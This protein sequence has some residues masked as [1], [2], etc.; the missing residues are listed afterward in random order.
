MCSSDLLKTYPEFE[1]KISGEF[2]DPLANLLEAFSRFGPGEQAWYQIILIPTDQKDF[3]VRAEKLINKIKGMEEK[4]KKTVLDQVIELPIQAVSEVLSVAMGGSTGSGKPVEKKN[5]TPRMLTLSPG[6]RYILEAVERKQSKIG[7]DCK[8][9]FLYVAKKEVMNKEKAANPFIGAIKQTN[10]F[11]MQALKPEMKRVGN[12]GALWWF[13]SQ[14]NNLRKNKMILAYR[15][16]SS[17]SGLPAFHMDSEELATL[18]HFPILMQVKAPRLRRI[19]A[20]KSEP[21]SNI[22]FG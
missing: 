2:K 4:K 9:R 7:F 17:W 8:M 6:E 3:R 19:E 12:S 1:D 16:R 10:T 18:W 15:N 5:E 11:N 13:K 20:K 21:P 14:R 22:P